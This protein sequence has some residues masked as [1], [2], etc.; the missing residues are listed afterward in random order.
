MAVRKKDSGIKLCGHLVMIIC[1]IWFASAHESEEDSKSSTAKLEDIVFSSMLKIVDTKFDTLTTRIT[2]LET[3]VSSLQLY[4]IRH[5]RQISGSLHSTQNGLETI[6]KQVTQIEQ[7][8][9]AQKPVISLLSH[10]VSELKKTSAELLS[11]F[12]SSVFYINENLDKQ[13]QFMK[14]LLEDTVVRSARETSD[15]IS[16][17]IEEMLIQMEKPKSEP[18]NCDVDFTGIS[19]H[20][21][22][23]F[24][25]F[26]MQTH[27]HFVKLINAAKFDLRRDKDFIGNDNKN[28][29]SKI[30]EE[31]KSCDCKTEPQKENNVSVET[32]TQPVTHPTNI[33]SDEPSVTK[34]VG[35][36]TSP[37]VQQMKYQDE[38]DERVMNALYNMT[39]SVL[40]AVS[41][42]RSTGR[43][44]EQVLSNTDLLAS[45]QSD[46]SRRLDMLQVPGYVSTQDGESDHS[47]VIPGA[48]NAVSQPYMLPKVNTAEK[49]CVLPID[50]FNNV[51]T[52][53]K[54]GSQLLEVLTD[55][56]QLSSVSLSKN[57]AALQDEVTRVEG[58]R[59]QMA[60]TMLARASGDESDPVTRLT[61]ATMRTFRLVE[62]VAS[63]TGWLPQI[64]NNI[65]HLES[66]TNRSLHATMQ[67]YALLS[68]A[69][70]TAASLESTASVNHAETTSSTSSRIPRTNGHRD[71]PSHGNLNE[72]SKD[73]ATLNRESLETIYSTSLQLNR[74]MPALTKLLSEPD[75]LITL[76]GGGRPDQ[77]RLEIYHNGQWGA[78]CHN[79]LSH[80]EADLICRHLGFRGGISAGAGHFGS[81]A[82]VTW[83][84]N[85]SCLATPECSVVTH[86]ESN[87]DCSHDLD[88]GVI[89]D[90]MLRIVSSD[91]STQGKVGRLEI[92]HRG[93][94]LPVCG[95][96]WSGYSARVACQQMGFSDGREIEVG[97][98][99][100][101]AN[102]TWLSNVA[103]TGHETR[104]DACHTDGWKDSCSGMVLA[105][106]RCV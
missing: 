28:D 4:S 103:C 84:F 38:N 95:L 51:A 58:V 3:S 17:L 11:E 10:D 34:D 27:A 62:A 83:V 70:Q 47:N 56:A 80:L 100:G 9:R 74:I 73:D 49:E 71:R 44:L 52:L 101:G 78:L 63:N 75:P 2:A 21:D 16:T 36:Q 5:F 33:K 64:F 40:Q 59:T 32:S 50:V 65:Q 8:D 67:N 31:E 91:G 61:N 106:V 69:Q 24:A 77:G 39:G 23:R 53:I 72:S 82:G 15:H 88:T 85:A 46:L 41:Y 25:E 20:I 79:D 104:L 13:G 57:T 45:Q 12:E 98:W 26:K 42:F 43:L 89:C 93:V 19:E 102:S 30:K 7:D 18:V 87:S 99:Q 54:N 60:T 37:G 97:K 81:G 35:A 29:D 96:G 94:W 68:K 1:T 90:H 14:S 48:D 92:H 105:G 55:L 22:L 86:S 6:G 76:V 66:L